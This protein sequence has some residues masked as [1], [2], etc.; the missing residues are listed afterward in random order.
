MKSWSIKADPLVSIIA[1][2]ALAVILPTIVVTCNA[3]RVK[4]ACAQGYAACVKSN[5]T[6]CTE[7]LKECS[8]F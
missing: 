5:K 6:D 4:E 7:A 8:K 3:A 2:I 1:V